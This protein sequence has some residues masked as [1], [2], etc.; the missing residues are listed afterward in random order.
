MRAVVLLWS[1]HWAFHRTCNGWITFCGKYICSVCVCADLAGQKT[2]NVSESSAATT[3]TNYDLKIGSATSDT[4]LHMH[5]KSTW[6]IS[7]ALLFST[8]SRRDIRENSKAPTFPTNE[9]KINP[10]RKLRSRSRWNLGGTMLKTLQKCRYKIHGPIRH[11]SP[12]S[13]KKYNKN[14]ADIRAAKQN[15]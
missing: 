11:L 13:T 4:T 8:R 5:K 2:D 9:I 10:Y 6:K 3:N 15:P 12:D 14:L 7:K 1:H